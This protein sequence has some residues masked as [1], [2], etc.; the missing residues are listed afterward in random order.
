VT[1]E[2]AALASEIFISIRNNAVKATVVKFPF[3]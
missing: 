2:H 3:V 1:T